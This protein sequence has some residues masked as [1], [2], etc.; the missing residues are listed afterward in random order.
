MSSSFR[1]PLCLIATFSHDWL[2]EAPREG[3]EPH[4]VECFLSIERI[5]GL[6]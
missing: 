4:G 1:A 6:V 2:A 3:A 5:H